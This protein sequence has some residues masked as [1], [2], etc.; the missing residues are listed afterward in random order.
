MAVWLEEVCN[1]GLGDLNM[2]HS[3]YEILDHLPRRRKVALCKPYDVL[4]KVI[5][6]LW[7]SLYA[8]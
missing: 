8:A 4:Y 2:G 6:L 7:G 5:L 1:L 3:A